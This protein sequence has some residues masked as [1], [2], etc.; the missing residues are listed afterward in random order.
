M[1]FVWLDQRQSVDTL[2]VSAPTSV[3][4]ERVDMNLAIRFYTRYPSVGF[5]I[6]GRL[7]TD[8]RRSS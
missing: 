7:N 5:L 2:M 3:K 4:Q 6:A 1:E 8:S